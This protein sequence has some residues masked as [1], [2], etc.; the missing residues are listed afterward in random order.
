MWVYFLQPW[1]V[2]KGGGRVLCGYVCVGV[3]V[4]VC[5]HVSLSLSLPFPLPPPSLTGGSMLM[6]GRPRRSRRPAEFS[7][8]MHHEAGGRHAIT[9]CQWW[10]SLVGGG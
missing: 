10:W 1:G 7:G 3:C 6:M 2:K 9:W 8:V 4:G 5:G